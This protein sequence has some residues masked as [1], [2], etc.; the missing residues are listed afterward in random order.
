MEKQEEV[1]TMKLRAIETTA[2]SF[3]EYG[4]VI[5]ASADG[6]E[7][8]PQDAQLDLSRGI[9]SVTQ[10]L[11]SIGG[12]VWYLG[13]AKPSILDST[14]TEGDMGT[15]I[16]RSHCGHFYVPPA[17]EDVRVFKIAGPKFLKLNRGTWHA[18]PLFKA[19]DMDFYNLELSNTNV[20]DH[21]THNFKKN[22]V[23]YT[24]DD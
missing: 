8:G 4:Q 16:V 17:I 23:V 22:G 2:E 15:N 9:P 3:K 21:T 7:F 13:V 5:E 20:V 14:E 19:D 11:G 12:H 18:G 10:C 1:V 24:I 6:E